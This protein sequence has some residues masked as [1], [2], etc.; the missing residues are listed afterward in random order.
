[1]SKNVKPKKKSKKTNTVKTGYPYDK[2]PGYNRNR[3]DYYRISDGVR[4]SSKFAHANPLS[5]EVEDE[6]EEEEEQD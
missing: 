3:G 1:M 5:T 4:V 2:V 6:E